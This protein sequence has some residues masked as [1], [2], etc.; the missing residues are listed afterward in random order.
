LVDDNLQTPKRENLK[1]DQRASESNKPIRRGG[2]VFWPAFGIA[3]KVTNIKSS[4]F[5]GYKMLIP[6]TS[7]SIVWFGFFHPLGETWNSTRLTRNA[8]VRDQL[9]HFNWEP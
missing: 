7:Y 3:P 9:G 2:L 1:Q 6:V 8:I 4:R 5:K